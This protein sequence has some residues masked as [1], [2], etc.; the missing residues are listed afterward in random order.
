MKVRYWQ[1]PYW[2][3]DSV[4]FVSNTQLGSSSYLRGRA[5]YD[6]YDNALY[7]YDDATYTTQAKSSSFKSLYHDHTVGGSVEWG[8]DAGP[9]HACARRATSSRT[10]HQDHNLGE[11]VKEFDGRI[12]SVGV[13]DTIDAGAEAVAG[14]R[15]QRRLAG[16]HA[17]PW[18]TRRGR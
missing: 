17:R 3:K 1:W 9:P 15:R 6:T 10:A 5:F 14:R 16:D 12:V 2:D 18:T 11:P 7:S 4:Y 13:E 8:S